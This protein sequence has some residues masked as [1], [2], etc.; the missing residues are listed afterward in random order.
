[1][2]H[3]GARSDQACP[4]RRSHP[5]PARSFWAGRVAALRPRQVVSWR[6]IAALVVLAFLAPRRRA[7]LARS[8]ADR[9][10]SR[11]KKQSPSQAQSFAEGIAARLG[12]TADYVQ[13]AFEDPADRMLKQGT[14]PENIDPSDPKLDDPMER[15]RLLR[16]FDAHLT[17]P[18][19]YVL[20]V[21]RWA[22]QATPGWLSEMW[23]TAAR[24]A[25]PDPGDSPLG[26][27]LPLQSLP[28][29]NPSTIRIWC[30][31]IPWKNG[32]RCPTRP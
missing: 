19:G 9:A 7:D 4:R 13:P 12:I 20:P 15:A 23:R 25:I 30:R 17:Q 11:N 8:R 10:R 14:L 18:A 21:Q 5:P 31:P 2:E 26:L 24:P 28:Y 27:R 16:L 1:M 29:F 3:R 32:H 22:T 6:A